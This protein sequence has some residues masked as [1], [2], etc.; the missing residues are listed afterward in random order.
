M[1]SSPPWKYLEARHKGL[2]LHRDQNNDGW[3]V[4]LIFGANLK[5][6]DQR[7]ITYALRLPCPGWSL[8]IGDFRHLLHC[9][10]SGSGLRFSLVL[11]LHKSV[12]TG[13]DEFDRDVHGHVHK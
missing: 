7:Y 10:E 4:V 13:V 6:F 9:V 8:V 2:Y 12:T 3:G 5:G 1:R 11:A